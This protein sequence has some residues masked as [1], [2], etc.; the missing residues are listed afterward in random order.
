MS[1]VK[2][3]KDLFVWQKAIHLNV[4]V[5][6][7]TKKFPREEMFGLTSQIKRAANSV[8]LNIAEG[9]GRNTLKSYSS[10][11]RNSIGSL[12]EVECGFHLAVALEIIPESECNIIFN[13]VEEECKM[14]NSLITSLS[15]KIN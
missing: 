9:F 7:L 12:N 3:F 2:S 5:Y 6:Q 10:Y 13:L 8:A 4:H 14:L 11:L 1:K 15:K